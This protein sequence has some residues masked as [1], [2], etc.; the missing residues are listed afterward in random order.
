VIGWHCHQRLV[1]LSDN[2]VYFRKRCSVCGAV[3]SQRKRLPKP[4]GT[5]P[6]TGVCSEC[7][8]DEGRHLATC[9]YRWRL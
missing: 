5:D 9:P 7:D 3:F 4:P 6:R 8:G 2:P 1:P